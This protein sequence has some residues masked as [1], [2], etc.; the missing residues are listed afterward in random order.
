LITLIEIFGI[1]CANCEWL[2]KNVLQAVDELGVKARII[3]VEDFEMLIRRGISATP[4]LTIDS[5]I[6]SQGRV[7]SVEE[8]KEMIEEAR[9]EKAPK[10]TS[11]PAPEAKTTNPTCCCSNAGVLLYSCSGASNVGQITNEVAKALSAQGLGKF[12]CLAGVGSNGGGFIASAKKA[13][14]IVCL[15]GCAIKCAQKTLVH[16]GIEPAVQIVITDLGIKKVHDRL[17]P[18]R[19]EVDEIVK[20][21][22]S[23]LSS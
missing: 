23:Q 11:D 15:D 17:D 22:Q 18:T 13:N 12:S 20:S 3:K 6:R 14:R 19:E 16:A 9:K 1:G 21:V 4:G 7:P 5:E 2:M 8:I 10:P